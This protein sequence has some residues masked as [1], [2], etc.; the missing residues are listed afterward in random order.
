MIISETAERCVVFIQFGS[1]EELETFLE[2]ASIIVQPASQA[3]MWEAGR[4]WINYLKAR[5]EEMVCPKCGDKRTIKCDKC[6]EIIAGRQHI[7]SDFLIGGHAQIMAG[8]LLTRDR[9]IL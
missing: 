2:D 6:G 1:R 7:I 8:T 4:A 9:G 3:A 5:G